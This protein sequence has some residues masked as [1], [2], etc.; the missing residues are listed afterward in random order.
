MAQA[1]LAGIAWKYAALAI[2]NVFGTTYVQYRP[3]IVGPVGGVPP[4]PIQSGNILAEALPGYFTTNAYKATPPPLD[5]LKPRCHAVF[6]PAT[7]QPGDYLLGPLS[8]GGVTET[9]FIFDN[10]SPSPPLAM[11]CD[12]VVNV[13]RGVVPLVFGPQA[14]LDA[15]LGNGVGVMVGWPASILRDG[16]GQ[17]GDVKLPGDVKLGGFLVNLPPNLPV[18]LRSGDAI[19]VTSWFSS[20]AP[21]PL[22]LIVV[23]AVGG[24]DGWLLQCEEAAS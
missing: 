9:F 20:P 15:Q 19:T 12:G 22:R 7:I 3:G 10:S 23:A 13:D 24:N 5:S 4:V 2:S 14:P 8:V 21:D 11:R 18:A 16:R 1:G 17:G 6:D